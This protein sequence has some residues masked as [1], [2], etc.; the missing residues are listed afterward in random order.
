M[1]YQYDRYYNKNRESSTQDNKIYLKH[2]LI[3]DISYHEL[4]ILLKRIF[5][6]MSAFLASIYYR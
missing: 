2:S 5:L 6:I 3:E 4:R 1:G